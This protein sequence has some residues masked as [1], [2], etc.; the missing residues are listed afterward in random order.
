MYWRKKSNNIKER[1]KNEPNKNKRKLLFVERE[2]RTNGMKIETVP[3]EL[4]F[5]FAIF[6]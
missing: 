3:N 6:S 1:K 4:S 2:V 5:S